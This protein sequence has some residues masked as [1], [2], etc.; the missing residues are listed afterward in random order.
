[1]WN[2]PKNDNIE[3]IELISFAH[4]PKWNGYYYLLLD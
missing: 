3:I 1:M 2:N 4:L